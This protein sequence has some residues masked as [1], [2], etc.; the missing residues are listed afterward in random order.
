MDAGA[1]FLS[2]LG[3]RKIE[4][5]FGANSAGRTYSEQLLQDDYKRDALRADSS[6]LR[7]RRQTPWSYAARGIRRSGAHAFA[8]TEN[9]RQGGEFQEDAASNYLRALAASR[10]QGLEAIRSRQG[11]L[12]DNE[13]S[14]IQRRQNS[15]LG[16]IF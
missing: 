14:G 2:A 7:Q 10:A 16:G 6:F 13:I 12:S 15:G 3:R 5:D 4:T 1:D 9:R 8:V 11:A